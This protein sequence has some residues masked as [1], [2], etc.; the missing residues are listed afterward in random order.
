M[1]VAGFSYHEALKTTLSDFFDEFSAELPELSDKGMWALS[2]LKDYSLRPSKRVR[3]SIAAMIVDSAKGTTNDPAALRLGA[4]IE[5]IQNHL[6]IVDDVM[7]RSAMRRGEPTAHK[8]YEHAFSPAD[9]REAEMVGVLVGMIAQHASSLLLLST[10]ASHTNIHDAL[11]ILERS[12]L[13]T[14]IGQI[15]DIDQQIDKGVSTDALLRKYAQKSSYYSFVAPLE[16]A[17]AL[18]NGQSDTAHA[19]A[20]AFGIAAGIAFQLRD[21]YLGIYGETDKTG[22][23]N[24][25]DIHEG[26]YTYMIH[27]ALQVASEEQGNELRS[28]LGNDLA[29]ETELQRVRDI[30]DTTGAKHEALRLGE[31]YGTQAKTAARTA[32]SWGATEAGILESLITFA[33]EREN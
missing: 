15:D 22:K 8:L 30:L 20:E 9:S 25:D 7:D 31:S 19:D 26:K 33:M 24:L 29:G 4:A 27:Q 1:N 3:G 13:I 16:A 14:D 32:T 28:I 23:P 6:L 18:V 17:L 21:D 2:I 10:N 5:L 11:R 12:T